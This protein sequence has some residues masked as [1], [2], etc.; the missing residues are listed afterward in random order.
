V[1]E[2]GDPTEPIGV[3]PARSQANLSQR[4]FRAEAGLV[5]LKAYEDIIRST[6]ERSVRDEERISELIN[7]LEKAN[8]SIEELRAELKT[9]NDKVVHQG[10]LLKDY[11]T[12]LSI[13]TKLIDISHGVETA[14]KSPQPPADA[15]NPPAPPVSVPNNLLRPVPSS[16]KS[17]PA[18]VKPSDVEPLH[19]WVSM[20]RP[21][22]TGNESWN[23]PSNPQAAFLPQP[24]FRVGFDSFGDDAASQGHYGG[25]I[26]P[27]DNPPTTGIWNTPGTSTRAYDQSD[28]SSASSHW[29]TPS[30]GKT[31]YQPFIPNDIFH[32]NTTLPDTRSTEGTQRFPVA[33][34]GDPS[35]AQ[36]VRQM[37]QVGG[38]DDASRKESSD[39]PFTRNTRS[40]TR[41]TQRDDS[42]S[43]GPALY[44]GGAGVDGGLDTGSGRG[45][46]GP[47]DRRRAHTPNSEAASVASSAQPKLGHT[48]SDMRTVLPS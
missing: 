39:N 1:V 9:A 36:P 28:R 11:R 17:G 15:H 42:S 12:S 2:P 30:G 16:S 20:D 48:V 8:S 10:D 27:Y 33:Q 38:G 41:G 29:N 21:S 23:D 32:G 45:G 44:I 5:G 40:T 34:N 35:F 26:P 25:I 47:D 43:K 19:G 18:T 37:S 3:A 13:L 24:S 22:L 6:A 14:S 7:G 31:G 46:G 4:I